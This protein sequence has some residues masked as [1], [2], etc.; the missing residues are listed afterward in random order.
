MVGLPISNRKVS[1]KFFFC[2][3]E[4]VDITSRYTYILYIIFMNLELLHTAGFHQIAE[5]CLLSYR[6]I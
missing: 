2:L 3:F 5:Q 6:I 1:Q 4:I